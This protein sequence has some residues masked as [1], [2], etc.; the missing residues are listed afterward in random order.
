MK[1]AIRITAVLAALLLP[2][3]AAEAASIQAGVAKVE[4]TDR[5]AG[6]VNDPSY[7]KALVLKNANSVVVIVT[8]DAVA[9]GEIGRLGSG[10]LASVRTQ[11]EKELG[12]HQAMCS[13]MPAIVIAWWVRT[14]PR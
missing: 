9:V 14:P 12:I 7:A 6:P 13:S 1:L 8:V 3:L 5:D 10:Y 4:I 2:P 11:L